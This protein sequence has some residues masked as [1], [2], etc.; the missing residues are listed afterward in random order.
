MTYIDYLIIG[1]YLFLSLGVSVWVFKS[2]SLSKQHYFLGNRQIP[3]WWAGISIAATT[4]AADT[5]LAITG[6]VAKQGLS[7]NWIWLS[8]I[9]MHA[10]IVVYFAR[11]WRSSQ[12]ITDA[13]IITLRYSGPAADYLRLFK[14]GFYALVFNGI[15]LSWVIRAMIKIVAPFIETSVLNGYEVYLLTF[16]VAIYSATGGLNA[17]II[18]DLFQLLI[19]LV[20][21]YTFGYFALDYIGGIDQLAPK[22]NQLYSHQTFTQFLPH[23]HNSS[24]DQLAFWVA[25]LFILYIIT[26]AFANN[27]ADGG[28]YIMQRLGACATPTEAKKAGLLFI[29]IQYVVRLWPWL[30]VALVALVV[31]P[32]G[33]EHIVFNG[34]YE[35]LTADREA[36]Y[37]ALIKLLLPTGVLGFVLVGMLAAFMSTI[38]THLNWGS[39]YIVNDLTPKL[40]TQLSEKKQVHLGRICSLS[41][42]IIGVIGSFYIENI[43]S[44][45]QWLALLGASFAPPTLLRWFWWR[46]NVFSEWASILFG[47]ITLIIIKT[48][49]DIEFNS[50]LILTGLS[51]IIGAVLAAI[52]LPSTTHK[53]L[54][55]F[56]ALIKPFGFWGIYQTQPSRLSYLAI[57]QYLLLIGGVVITFFIGEAWINLNT[58]YLISYILIE[59]F[60]IGLYIR[61]DK[62]L[63]LTL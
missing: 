59:I 53:Q 9:L 6:L 40:W 29:F 25:P 3:W 21:S 4:F 22:L 33:Q 60:V 58:N 36:A 55:Q 1:I 12:V 10:A 8:W 17:V 54:Q 7:G 11:Y 13:E 2:S 18:T 44:A 63:S 24:A 62:K 61:V 16:L 50:Q 23:S 46:V 34:A 26:Q 27:P 43:S 19:A 5:P 32:I 47:L 38:D 41:F 39:S 49:F 31:F 42:A 51:A 56:T 28:G 30:V 14:S 45:W 15:I 20:G 37:P 52:Y 48:Q 57:T 35:Y